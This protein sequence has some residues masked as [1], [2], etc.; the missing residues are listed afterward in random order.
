MDPGASEQQFACKNLSI[1]GSKINGSNLSLKIISL[2]KSHLRKEPVYLHHLRCHV[3]LT[4]FTIIFSG[5]LK[6]S[7]R[8]KFLLPKHGLLCNL[9]ER[10][11]IHR[12][13]SFSWWQ[14]NIPEY[15]YYGYIA[16]RKALNLKNCS[17][18]C[19]I[20]RVGRFL[21][22]WIF[23]QIFYINFWLI[24]SLA[25]KFQFAFIYE[26]LE[27]TFPSNW[28]ILLSQFSVQ[29]CYLKLIDIILVT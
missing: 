21:M 1:T 24:S 22:P 3:S 23:L 20:R 16:T 12:L 18:D 11:Y 28:T 27:Y 8:L 6:Y 4:F 7:I 26:K 13:T 25:F 2:T 10:F 14:F 29:P 9:N 19:P 15:R 5:N 17:Q